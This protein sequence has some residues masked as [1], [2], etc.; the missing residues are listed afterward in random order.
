[1][2][3]WVGSPLL[4]GQMGVWE[5]WPWSTLFWLFCSHLHQAPVKSSLT[6]YQ[7]PDGEGHYS[8]NRCLL[9]SFQELS[10]H[11][12]G[13]GNT[14]AGGH[15][16]RLIYWLLFCYVYQFTTGLGESAT[17]CLTQT[18]FYMLSTANQ[19]LV[20]DLFLFYAPSAKPVR[21]GIGCPFH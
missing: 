13:S 1:M 9:M 18:I 2:V 20:T 5:K 15:S 3:S 17:I 12:E 16:L 7:G 10:L 14:K 19:L 21:W 8:A 11:I 6:V 4:E